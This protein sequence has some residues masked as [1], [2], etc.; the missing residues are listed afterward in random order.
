MHQAPNSPLSQD[1]IHAWVDARLPAEQLHAVDAQLSQHPAQHEDA[2]QWK[3][4]ADALQALHLDALQEPVPAHLLESAQRM[5][6]HRHQVQQWSHWG[7]MAASVALAF[8]C[9]WWIRPAL[10]PGYDIAHTSPALSQ[11][12]VQQAS[13]A[14]AVYTTE[15]RHPVEVTSAEQAHLVQW[16]SK[17]LGRTLRVPD[18]SA[19]GYILMGGR[20]L[21]GDTGAR[22]QFMFQNTRG[23]RI[24]LYVGGVTEPSAS[25]LQDTVFQ[26]SNQ[27][28]NRSFYWVDRGFGYAM[29]GALERSELMALSEAVYS[30]LGAP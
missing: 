7:G 5:N 15:V 6:E 13:A 3:A 1:A 30:Q 27:G 24:T 28:S 16:L 26:F 21:P 12:F 29:T 22:A 4:Q 8:A 2:M 10:S 14:Y 20:L 18:L 17:R 11:V 23:A 9:G 19:Q 25:A